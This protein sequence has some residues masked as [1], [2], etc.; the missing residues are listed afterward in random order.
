[1]RERY[2]ER[3]FAVFHQG[4]AAYLFEGRS[5]AERYEGAEGGTV[6]Y[7]QA[8]QQPD[9]LVFRFGAWV[10][11]VWDRGYMTQKDKALWARSLLGRESAEGYLVLT[12]RA[13]LRLAR[14]GEHAGPELMF[15]DSLRRSVLLFH[16]PCRGRRVS[17]SSWFSSWCVPTAD[18]RVHVYG[19]RR[20]ANAVEAGLRIRMLRPG[21]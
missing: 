1:M 6:E 4:S 16:T 2:C 18:V 14:A 10:L 12:A 13:P 8:R 7:W 15:G 21:C 17:R 19:P 5:L 9:F 20:F 3:D 11:A